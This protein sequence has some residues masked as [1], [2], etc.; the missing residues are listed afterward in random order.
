MNSL[1]P[2]W[3]LILGGSLRA[4]A[5][6]VCILLLRCVLRGRFSAQCFHFLW[7]LTAVRLL[8]PVAPGSP[9]SIFN[10][11]STKQP[12]PE[13]PAS[14]W[15]VRKE[16]VAAASA[17]TVA[18]HAEIS[19]PPST[20]GPNAA[21]LL[22]SLWLGG[23][24]LQLLLLGRSMHRMSHALRDATLATDPR[25]LAMTHQ[26]AR[27]VGLRRIAQVLET[28][29]VTGPAVAGLFRSRLLLPRGFAERLSDQQLRSVLLHE[30]AHLRRYDIGSMWLWRIARIIHWFNPLVWLAYRAA[31]TDTELACDETVLRHTDHDA[32][33]AYGETLL[34]LAQ[35]VTWR[36]PQLPVAG[37]LEGKRA[38][39]SRL[40]G[41]ARYTPR[42]RRHTCAAALLILSVGL[43]FAAD[44]KAPPPA[45]LSNPGKRNDGREPRGEEVS[46]PAPKLPPWADGWSVVSIVLPLDGVL[47][48]AEIDLETGP[49]Q[50]TTLTAGSAS[51]TE[52]W[53]EK[54][55]RLP[56]TEQ[57][58]VLLR[59]GSERV[60]LTVGADLV[61]RRALQVEIEAKFF[62]LTE[63]TVRRLALGK[64]GTQMRDRTGLDL[65]SAAFR[66]GPHVNVLSAGQAEELCK[67]IA[68]Q[69]GIDLLSAPRV[70]AK[71]GQRAVIEIVREFRYATDWK[72]DAQ[73]GLWIATAYETRNTGVT[74]Q[75]E[76][77]VRTPGTIVLRLVPQVVKFLGFRDI[78]S[79]K[80][81]STWA[82]GKTRLQSFFSTR[83]VETTTSL[84]DGRTV[85]I[86]PLPE[87]ENIE[88]VRSTRTAQ[89]VIA[90]I[91]ARVV[92]PSEDF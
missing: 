91:S 64:A 22:A 65:L 75:A 43:V 52:P 38:L 10:I 2:L 33:R 28:G 3:N 68:N 9:V 11:H 87:T 69:R 19:A 4:C 47:E 48:K 16:T 41:I 39:R 92:G 14:G 60:A 57:W 77:K 5:L 88:P 51:E 54:V 66:G 58:K 34:A 73:N 84:P 49:E 12:P 45:G 46:Q 21:A 78:D 44:E 8:L 37:I 24:F 26:C 83:K 13:S 82:P 72:R 76:P 17:L 53:V 27:D 42:S 61:R 74:L 67:L 89:H 56:E 79:G 32:A 63:T 86:G 15:V 18:Q 23:V 31:R 80:G 85:L 36:Q 29:G 20:D 50:T 90:M 35:L 1:D 71:S 70:T 55:E 25:L 81:I 7:L 30:C 59:K 62:E 6:I 40:I